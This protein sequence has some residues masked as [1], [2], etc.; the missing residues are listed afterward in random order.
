MGDLLRIQD[1]K[2]HLA[3]Q[4]AIHAHKSAS[5]SKTHFCS[6]HQT[7]DHHVDDC[8]DFQNSIKELI[9]S[10][11]VKIIDDNPSYSKNNSFPQSQNNKLTLINDQDRLATRIFW[12][13]KYDKNVV[14]PFVKFSTK[15]KEG[16]GYCLFHHGGSHSLG[17]CKE[18]KEFIQ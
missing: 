8:S 3:R 17:K 11:K 7:H 2:D 13:L 4:Q 18:F 9:N 15:H 12:K 10:D 5:S 6:F 14:F 16:S 1:F